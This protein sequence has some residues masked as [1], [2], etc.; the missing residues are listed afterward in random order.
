MIQEAVIYEVQRGGGGPPGVL[1]SCYENDIPAI[2]EV[3]PIKVLKIS[4]TFLS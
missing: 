2:R 1:E 3:L 4:G